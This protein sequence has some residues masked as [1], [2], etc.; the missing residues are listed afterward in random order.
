[1]ESQPAGELWAGQAERL[2]TLLE[3]N[4]AV[5]SNLTHEPLF[6]AVAQ[7]L[8]R[9]V[10]F[11]RSAIFLHDPEKAV[12]RLFMLESS[13]PSS[14]FVIGLEM[15]PGDSHVGWV[16]QHQQ[17]LL[18]RD[19][20]RESQYPMEERALADGVRSYV[21]VPLISG[22][23]SI[24]ALAVASTK[25]GQYTEAD[26]AFLQE[27]ANQ[28]ALAVHNMNSYEALQREVALRRRAEG[29]LRA[30]M[31][32][33]ASVTGS[34]FFSSLARH[35]AS[36]FDARCALV[37]EWLDRARGRVRMLAFWQGAGLD[38]NIEYDVGSTPC[39]E[40]LDGS[41]RHYPKDLHGLFPACRDVVGFDAESYLGIPIL[42]SQGRVMGHLAV[43]DDRPMDENGERL[44]VLQIFAA[45]AG[46]EIERNLA[47]ASL[48]EMHQFNREVID[49]ASEG[50]IVYD[51][52]LR[53][54]VFNRFMEELTGKPGS[55]VLG[56]Y[57]P[58]V[59]PFLHEKGMD[60]MLR[61]AMRGEIVTCPDILIQMPTGRVVWE[62]NRYGPYRDAQGD[63][64]GVIALVSDITQR[65]QAE[66]ALR[67]A[68]KEVESLKNRLQ[69]E[70][71]YLQEEIRREHNFVELVGTSPSL[72]AVLG[73]VEQVAPTDST[74]LL[75]GETG[76]GKE[77]IARAIHNRSA[78][79]DRPL[80]K[81]NCA[82]ISAG[83]VE[84]ELFGHL[85]G[86]FTGAL[87]RR[88]GRFELADGGTIFLDEVGELPLETQVKLLRVLQDGEFEPVGSSKTVCVD[89]RVIA[90][91]NRNLGDAVQ[92][93]RF[94]A[95]LFFRLNVFP[96]VLPPLRS[97]LSDLPQLVAFFV[98]RYARKFGKRV[99]AV[100]QETLDRLAGY[101]WPG[102]IRELQNIVERAVI[103]SQ[104][105][106]L[107]LGADLL[108]AATTGDRRADEPTPHPGRQ[109]LASG[110]AA[111]G[112][113]ESAPSPLITLEEMERNHILAV[114][115]KSRGVIEG[116]MGAAT[117]LKL[118]PNT[119]RSRMKKLGIK[120]P[121]HLIS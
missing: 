42:G 54:V 60:A 99:E 14:Y 79:K 71:V 64:K 47:E 120:R 13:L 119:L 103:L 101:P 65:K 95:D 33:T 59:F 25:P 38:E 77:L 108:P 49:G 88:V 62:L 48:R 37:T 15:P 10:P 45:R 96:L 115:Q 100:S 4:N 43:L 85:K 106:I 28:V 34:E 1:M 69:A 12:L 93:G 17:S 32:G 116:P 104:G 102:N 3:I 24:G 107:E 80:V 74:V 87:E 113:Q 83:L 40:V 114:L 86:A 57:A 23:K 53:Y 92:E 8:R 112:L 70:N 58:D 20:Q 30:I 84:S 51:T 35:L 98:S 18:R 31:E 63:I 111:R 11:D 90:A 52:E 5:I 2:R 78:R 94:R 105:P 89:V 118:H 16:F 73:Q 39:R 6:R 66:E 82:A 117:I 22:G 91:T 9:V 41:I 97:R 7:S 75:L 72:V 68:L 55:E 76:T 26:G 50:I 21:I 29:V 61:Q 109:A 67:N 27:V 110:A 121:T 44:P 81:V 36:T 56:R 19:L 46:A